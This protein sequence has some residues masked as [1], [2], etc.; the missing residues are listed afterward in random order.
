V[1]SVPLAFIPEDYG[2]WSA[3]AGA[4]IYTFGANLEEVNQDDTP[5]VVGTW[6]IGFT[7]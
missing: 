5:W 6:S 2:S 3:S 7:Y 1:L 4:S